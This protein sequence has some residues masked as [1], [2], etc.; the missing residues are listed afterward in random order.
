MPIIKC[1]LCDKDYKVSP[2]QR[3]N[4]EKA[5]FIVYCRKCADKLNIT[6]FKA[7]IDKIKIYKM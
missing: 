3:Y 5:G 1:D 4:L 2:Q 6:P 7:K